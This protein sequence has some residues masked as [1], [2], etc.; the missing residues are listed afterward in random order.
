MMLFVVN[1]CCFVFVFF[2]GMLLFFFFV[3]CFLMS[4][5]K[6]ISLFSGGLDSILATRLILDQGIDVVAFNVKTLFT[7]SKRA[8]VSEVE[9]G[10][11]ELGV[12][13]E[14]VCADREYICM[15]RSPKF[16]YGRNFNPCIDCKIFILRQ[17]KKF[18]RKVGADFLFTGEVL[19]ERPM[20]Q[21]GPALRV[22]EEETGLKGE[23]LRPLSAKLLP[24]T[25]AERRGFVDR[26]KL[27]GISGRS[28]K[29]QFQ[30]AKEFG[31]VN[32]PSP[33]GGCLLTCEEYS[34]KLCDL[35]E[36]KKNVSSADVV[37]LRFGR[38]FR[39]GINKIV[40]GRNEAENKFLLSSKGVGDY[41]F[42]LSDVVG[43]V[44]ILQGLKRGEAVRVAAQLTA[45][46]SDAKTESVKVNY[47][48]NLLDKSIIVKRP[49]REEVDMLRAGKNGVHINNNNP[50]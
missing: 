22:I 26:E 1:V 30:L 40:V 9:S 7:T 28:R 35:F 36:H 17:A 37:L 3:E 25:L 33:A 32:F 41:C 39:F 18:A 50:V 38:H 4:R 47:G 6:A 11:L 29:P 34:K 10:A 24:E 31:I 21:H 20:S 27:L 14:V 43:P 16:G 8:G 12:P 44:G 2:I 19:G 46:Y 49:G 23:L 42:E 15:L 48:K 45:F 13:L 5:V